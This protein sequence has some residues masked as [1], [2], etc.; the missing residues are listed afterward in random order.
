MLLQL[1]LLLAIF[2]RYDR[3][4][5][6]SNSELR[7]RNQF[8][9]KLRESVLEEQWVQKKQFDEFI[10]ES[11]MCHLNFYVRVVGG[12]IINRLKDLKWKKQ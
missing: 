10:C 2:T 6:T 11:E 5:V 12:K 7:G 4:I 3:I 1:A 8:G 9:V